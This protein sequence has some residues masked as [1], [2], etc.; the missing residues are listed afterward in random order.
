MRHIVQI[1][2]FIV[3]I[4]AAALAQGTA[5]AP[6]VQP[7]QVLSTNPFGAM[8]KWVNAEYE[9]KIGPATTLG[10]SAS[11]FADFDQSNAAV[12]L[13]WY[14]DRS[15][16][17]GFYVGTRAGAYRFATVTFDRYPSFH[18]QTT[19][20]PGVGIEVGYNWMLGP[21]QNVSVGIGGGLIRILGSG[22]RYDVPSVLPAVRLVNLG[23]AF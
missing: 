1:A 21:K 20:L 2:L 10:A 5:A 13:R 19:V 17:R 22:D 11:Y 15:A 7:N 18:E 23:I 12:L 16:L 8:L 9:R 14:P 6:A 4:P 3:F